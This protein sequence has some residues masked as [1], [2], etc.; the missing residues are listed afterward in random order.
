MDSIDPKHVD[1]F[2]VDRTTIKFQAEASFCSLRLKLSLSPL[3]NECALRYQWS[4]ARSLLGGS[5]QPDHGCL[6][7][8]PSKPRTSRAALIMK[9]SAFPID[10][11]CSKFTCTFSEDMVR[12]IEAVILNYRSIWPKLP[13]LPLLIS[14]DAAP[15]SLL[16]PLQFCYSF[17]IS[18]APTPD[19]LSELD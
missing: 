8:M 16:Q 12:A 18:V 4:R 14:K 10:L 19:S 17:E 2:H 5:N 6:H 3:S 15:V 7:E 9:S 13:S 1:K 11:P